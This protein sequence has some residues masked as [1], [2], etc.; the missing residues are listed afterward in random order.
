MKRGFTVALLG[1]DGA[2]KTTVARRLE[3]ELGLPVSY[4]YMGVNPDSS[5]RMLPTTRLVHE[6][7]RRRGAPPDTRGPREHA[8]LRAPR[9]RSPLQRAVRSTRSAARLAN[10]IAEECYREAISWRE[11]RRGHVVLYD[12]HFR[13]DYHA[14]DVAGGAELPL[15]RR[16]HGFFLSRVYPEP[17]LVVVLD[18][19]PEVLLARKG[20]GTLSSL[21]RRRQEYLDLRALTKHYAV[22]DAS[23]SL[24]DVVAEVKALVRRFAETRSLQGAP[25][26]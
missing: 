2:G 19:P 21:A 17:D 9:A 20:E 11:I 1:V 8:E 12:R 15:S 7:K 22:V 18:A 25:G 6:V 16:V 23:R 14:Y 4:L 26:R 10:R 24:D 3:D 13:A 5:N